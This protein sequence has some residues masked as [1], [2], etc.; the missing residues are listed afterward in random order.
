MSWEV[1]SSKQHKCPCGL[2]TYT[3][4]VLID[5]WNRTQQRSE[6]ECPVCRQNYALYT[7]Y[8]FED[9]LPTD[10]QLWVLRATYESF[11][12]LERQFSAAKE[13]VVDFAKSRYMDKWLDYFAE[14]KSKKEVWQRLTDNGAKYPS[15]ST[16]YDHVKRWGLGTYLKG[17][18]MYENLP[19]ILAKL[20]VT[21]D[22]VGKKL[23]ATNEIAKQVENAKAQL[24]REGHK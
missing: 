4:T 1:M 3:I 16:F 12:Q 2:G 7:Y 17:E 18:F 10:A 15:L 9:G 19:L 11:T 22:K 23:R 13:E 6:M 8:I 24:I 20:L 5:D 21:D 14:A